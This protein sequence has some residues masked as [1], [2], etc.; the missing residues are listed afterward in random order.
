MMSNIATLWVLPPTVRRRQRAWESDSRWARESRQVEDSLVGSRPRTLTRRDRHQF[1]PLAC[2]TPLQAKGLELL[3]RI[4][5]G[6]FPVTFQSEL[7]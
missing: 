5:N 6:S 3:G 7:A 1:E 2:K 4:P